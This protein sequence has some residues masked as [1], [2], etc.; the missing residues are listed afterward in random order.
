MRVRRFIAVA[1]SVPLLTFAGAGAAVG[2]EVAGP[3]QDGFATGELTPVADYVANSICA[4]SGLNAY[5]PG[6]DD[7]FPSVQTYGAFVAAGDK[8]AV[9]SPGDAC[10]GHTGWLAG[11]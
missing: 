11:S 6:K 2:G 9:P 4:F 8:D 1:V 10:N 7:V 5:H 3:P